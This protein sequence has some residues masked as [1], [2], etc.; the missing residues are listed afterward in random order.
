MEELFTLKE[1]AAKLKLSPTTLYRHVELGLISC[2]R[3]ISNNQIRF[4]ES[5]IRQYLSE[6]APSSGSK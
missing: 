4:T 2:S 5:Q 3:I 6:K 1:A